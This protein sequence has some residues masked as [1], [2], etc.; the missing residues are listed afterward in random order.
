MTHLDVSIRRDTAVKL[1]SW[2]K[3]A[4]D[5]PSRSQHICSSRRELYYFGNAFSDKGVLTVSARGTGQRGNLDESKR[6][7]PS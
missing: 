2:N 6:F 3:A 5:C 7:D 4:A 1:R